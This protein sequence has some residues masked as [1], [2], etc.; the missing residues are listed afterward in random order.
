VGVV[1]SSRQFD[2][3]SEPDPEIFTNYQ[4][5]E[6]SYMYVLVRTKGDPTALAPAIR[7][8]VAE[9][10][11]DQP[12]GHR[13]LVQQ[14]D[15]AVSGTRSYTLLV[16]IFAGLALLLASVGVYGVMSYAVSQR[17]QEIGVRMA[18]G[19][20]RNDVLRLFLGRSLKIVTGGVAAG[21]GLALA[22]NRVVANLLFDVKTTDAITFIS[23]ALL[24]GAA[25]VVA[26]YVPAR[27][28]TR[29][30]PLVALRHE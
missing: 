14:L 12:V 1:G 6:M 5:S 7:H 16:G 22:I 27:K 15:N 10:D 2:I 26:S 18:L 4:Q 24:L 8:A 19:A 9:I 21:L 17:T 30:D 11:P 3:T 23:A 20:Q 13:T 28:A 29:V 25:T